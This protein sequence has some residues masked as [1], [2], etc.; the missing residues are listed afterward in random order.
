MLI[1]Q[2][3]MPKLKGMGI[4]FCLLL[5]FLSQGYS[6]EKP[7]KEETKK[8]AWNRAAMNIGHFYG[9]IVDES[10]KGI[11]YASVQLLGMKFDPKTKTRSQGVIAGQIT[12]ENGDFSLEKLPIMGEFTL[13]IT[14]LGYADMEQKVSFGIKRPEGGAQAGQRPG[15]GRAGGWGGRA[16]GGNT[17][18]DLGNIKLVPEATTL[19]EV[20]IEREATL[21]KLELDKKIFRVDQNSVAAGGTAEDALR[22]VPSLSVDI[23]GNL[24]LRNAAPQL[25]IDGRP[26]TLTLD[27]ISSDE[28]ESV[29]VITNPSAKYDASGGQAGI[30][31]LVLKK[32]RRIGYN[33]SVRAGVDTQGGFNGGGNVNIREGKVNFFLSANIFQRK[34]ISTGETD[35]F[36]LI[37]NPRTNIFQ[38]NE[39]AFTGSFSNLR[40]G[41]DWFIDNRNTLTFSGSL[42]RGNFDSDTDIDIRT[43]TVFSG[44]ETFSESMRFSTS[45]RMF[46]NLG[47][48]ILFKHLFPKKGR[49]WT[50]DVNINQVSSDGIGSFT[51]QYTNFATRERQENGGGSRFLTMQTDFVEPFGKTGKIEAGIRAALRD[52]D[53]QNASFLYNTSGESWTR[54]PN[55]ADQYEFTDAVYA[56]YATF[57]QQF[58]G[59]SYQLGLRAESS[60]Y[61]GS[62]PEDGTVFENDFPFSFFPSI[63]LTKE[64]NKQDNVQLSYSRR[65]NRPSFFRL[66][67]FTDFSDSLNL[68]RGNPDLIPEFTNSLELTYQN[69]LTKGHDLLLSIYYKQATNLMTTYQFTE[70]IADKEVLISSYANSNNS[71][72]YGMEFTLRNTFSEHIEL[73]SNVNLYNS[74]VDASNIEPGL[75]NEQFTWFIKENLVIKLPAKLRLQITGEYQSPAAFVPSSG[76]GRFRGH[77][78]VSNTAQGYRKEYF[79]VDAAL[80]KDIL[81]RKASL[82]MSIRDIFKSRKT[83]SYTESGFFIQDSWRLRAPQVVSVNFSYRFGKPDSSLFKRKN[84]NFNSNGSD[85]MN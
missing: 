19:D 42:T 1:H 14:V 57:S 78:G 65:I 12:E 38:D 26:T 41:V 18:K 9:K 5:G 25:F 20:V 13:K 7:T 76:S 11:S 69:V 6:Q 34:S 79:F 31:N 23:D 66:M 73:T 85:M 4:L 24:T 54:V 72:A 74:K 16:G 36:N 61:K 45:E 40:T 35:R 48:S 22:N 68:R 81:K 17:D 29:E 60:Q 32:E 10:G 75:I 37:G 64:I 49:E 33:G 50:A 53:S 46:R 62:L 70:V 47:G 59:W 30:V 27:Q 80:R 44:G 51:N 39:R 15:G 58:T 71:E 3:A 67:P 2:T 63:F 82:T 83:G 55:F 8:P 52:Y 84:N 56:G 77:R 28:I 21:V 43:D